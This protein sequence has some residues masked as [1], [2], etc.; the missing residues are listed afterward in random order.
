[1]AGPPRDKGRGAGAVMVV[2]A[3]LGRCGRCQAY[4]ELGV[5]RF[6]IGGDIRHV[7]YFY[8][9]SSIVR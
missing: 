4:R 2:R 6:H 1:M 9:T 8:I 5:E 3:C 7:T